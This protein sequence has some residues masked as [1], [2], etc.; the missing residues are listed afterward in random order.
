MSNI[1][2]L[3]TTAL[4]T[5]A[6]FFRVMAAAG[7]DFTGPMQNRQQR[8]NLVRYLELDCPAVN[9]LVEYQPRKPATEEL[10]AVLLGDRFIPPSEIV[11]GGFR[12]SGELLRSLADSLPSVETLVWLREHNYI[13]VA[14]PPATLTLIDV[15]RTHQS[16]FR[17]HGEMAWFMREMHRFLDVDRVLPGRWRALSLDKP[18]RPAAVTVEEKELV[19]AESAMNITDVCYTLATYFTLRNPTLHIGRNYLT[20]SRLGTG[21]PVSALVCSAGIDV[22]H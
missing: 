2:H 20:T 6:K 22:Y 4:D 10:A 16:C 18:G 19:E 17:T 7:A 14:A 1:A 3:D 11:Y 8:A 21:T 12:H 15:Y 9:E 5:A 13:L